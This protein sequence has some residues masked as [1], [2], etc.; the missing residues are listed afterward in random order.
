MLEKQRFRSCQH[1]TKLSKLVAVVEMFKQTISD[2][3]SIVEMYRKV[4]KVDA[5]VSTAGN[6]HFG[7]LADFTES[8]FMV[9]LTE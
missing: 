2:R 3:D 1:G 6:V 7:P 9:G 4:G 8:Q 5:V